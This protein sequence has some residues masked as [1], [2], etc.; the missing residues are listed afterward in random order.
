MNIEN[1]N[2]IIENNENVVLLIVGKNTL[3]GDFAKSVFKKISKNLKI[4]ETSY[5]IL[6]IE[7]DSFEDPLPAL[8]IY[9][10]KHLINQLLGFHSS[11]YYTKWITD[12]LKSS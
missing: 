5:N 8:S 4:E 2:K 10:D 7:N 12:N 9:K 6:E 11:I 1:L 3:L